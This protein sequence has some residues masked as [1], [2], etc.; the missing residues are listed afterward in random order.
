MWALGLVG[1]TNQIHSD[2]AI[3]CEFKH[4]VGSAVP[5]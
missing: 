2:G 5:Q 3:S 4:S 1:A